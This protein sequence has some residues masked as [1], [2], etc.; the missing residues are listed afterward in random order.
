MLR[1]GSWSLLEFDVFASFFAPIENFRWHLE[2][3][4]SKSNISTSNRICILRVQLMHQMSQW[5]FDNTKPVL[6]SLSW[7]FNKPSSY[8]KLT[9]QHETNKDKCRQCCEVHD[10][11]NFLEGIII[12]KCLKWQQKLFMTRRTFSKLVVVKGWQWVRCGTRDE[13][14]H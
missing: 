2:E 13:S 6:A 5:T 3:S 12:C 4:S 10:S 9:K 11:D 1:S 7:L 14:W 8:I